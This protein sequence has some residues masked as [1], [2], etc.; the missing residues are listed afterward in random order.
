MDLRRL[1]YF[2]TIAKMGHITRAAAQLGIQQAPLSQQ[3]KVLE[4]EIGAQL[5]IR[6]PRGVELT[7]AGQTLLGYAQR[8]LEEVERAAAATRQVGEGTAGT[9]RLLTVRFG[10][11]NEISCR[12][13]PG[14]HRRV[15]TRPRQL[16][17][18]MKMSGLLEKLPASPR[19]AF[20]AWQHPSLP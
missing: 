15:T 4:Q 10:A 20:Y 11:E 16:S 6:K 19:R 13:Q 1:R 3:I 7:E 5:F 17:A 8:I 12:W 14:T 2:V 18:P 9:L